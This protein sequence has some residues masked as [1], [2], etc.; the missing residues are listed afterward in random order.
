VLD[1]VSVNPR[2]EPVDAAP[3]EEWQA[4]RAY[5]F[6]IKD[7]RLQLF[8]IRLQPNTDVHAHAHREDEIIVITAGEIH[9]GRR[10]LGVG[11]AVYVEQET[12]YGF[13]AGPAGCTFLNFRPGTTAGYIGKD[14]LMAQRRAAL[15]GG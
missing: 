13:K 8:E 11:A 12:L 9:V 6:P 7:E 3:H 15:H 5:Y 4:E 2:E 10:V 1:N 14:E